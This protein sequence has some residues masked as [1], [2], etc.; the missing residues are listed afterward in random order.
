[1]GPKFTDLSLVYEARKSKIAWLGPQGKVWHPLF[2]SIPVAG[3]LEFMIHNNP[4]KLINSWN[5]KIS[6][7]IKI[8][9]YDAIHQG[10]MGHAAACDVT[11]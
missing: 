9:N 6:R 1:M 10:N 5:Q 7:K 3:E 4:T 8:T 11:I 2:C